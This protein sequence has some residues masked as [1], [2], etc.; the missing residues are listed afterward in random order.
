LD[1]IGRRLRAVIK[2][3]GRESIGV[4]LGNPNGWNYGAFLS[5]IGLCAALK[6]KHFYGATSVYINNYWAR[7]AR[8]C[9]S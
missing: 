9:L 3:H 5:L 4:Y 8:S 1:D 6:T 7:P 2:S